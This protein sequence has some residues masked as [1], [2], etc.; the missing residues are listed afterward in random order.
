MNIKA[1]NTD[2]RSKTAA[3][4]SRDIFGGLMML[5]RLRAVD[6]R[7]VVQ[8]IVL[9][10]LSLF[11]EAFSISLVLPLMDMIGAKGDMAALQ[12][13]GRLWVVIGDICN[14]VSLK[15][16]IASLSVIILVLITIRQIV[17]YKQTMSLARM[18]HAIGRDLAIRM[19]ESIMRGHAQYIQSIGSG[20][21]VSAIDHQSQ[22]LAYLVQSYVTLFGI[23]LTFVAYGSIMFIA[24]PLT[25]V[26]AIIVGGVV[27]GLMSRWATISKQLSREVVEFREK[28]TGFLGERYRSWRL[29]KL[30]DSLETER[31]NIAKHSKRFFK[32]S[33]GLARAANRNQLYVAPTLMVIIL[34]CLNISVMYLDLSVATLTLFVIVMVRLMPTVQNFA[35]LR[36]AIATYS[37]LV[38]RVSELL[39]TAAANREIDTGSRIFEMLKRGIV[40]EHVSFGYQPGHVVINDLSAEIPAGKMTAIMGPSGAG[41]STMVD[42]L[43]RLILPTGGSILFDGVPLEDH[44]LKSLR[45]HMTVVSQQ[46]VIFSGTVRENVRY[47]R[48]DASD[49]Q[50]EAACRAAYADE[51][52]RE[53]PGGYDSMLAEG[54]TNISGG[55]RQRLMLARAF[56]MEASL[57]VL[58]EPTSSLDYESEQKIKLALTNMMSGGNVTLIVVAHRITTV[59]NA[60]HVIVI[61]DGSVIEQGPPSSLNRDDSWYASMLNFEDY[62]KDGNSIEQLQ[63]T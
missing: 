18:K 55:Q 41:K 4:F 37:P 51:F 62:S 10:V 56:L 46:P 47:V 9:T 39:Q 33:I 24:A 61:K 7:Q 34:L 48:P 63:A 15:P 16:T 32:L 14:Y 26:L 60:D 58:D 40:F 36:Q 49:A 50:V 28:F 25:S 12:R 43:P 23:V 3:N 2:P 52:I 45:G 6:V 8:I 53:M 27:V 31:Q 59:R 13:R 20:T 5:W 42:L 38:D 35:S 21:F 30:S 29:I 19:F 11:F 17:N 44:S 1:D 54:G 57:V 22:A